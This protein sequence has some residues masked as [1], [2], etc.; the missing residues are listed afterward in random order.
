M[1]LNAVTKSKRQCVREREREREREISAFNHCVIYH[2]LCYILISYVFYVQNKMKY[3]LR[4]ISP[5]EE[6]K[7]QYEEKNAVG[8]GQ[9]NDQS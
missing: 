9:V 5:N 4:Y 1:Q 7:L 6:K 8:E 3:E 2:E